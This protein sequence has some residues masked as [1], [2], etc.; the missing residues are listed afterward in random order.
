MRA[1]ISPIFVIIVG[2]QRANYLSRI[3]EYAI[4][5][6]HWDNRD[7]VGELRDDIE[8]E[9]NSTEDLSYQ[10]FSRKIAQEELNAADDE[11]IAGIVIIS[12][13]RE[14]LRLSLVLEFDTCDKIHLL[15][16]FHIEYE[17]F[18]KSSSQ[19]LLIVS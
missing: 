8:Y 9:K 1:C 6:I 16:Q 17:D 12:F 13:I 11:K 15:D 19:F 14:G 2:R 3:L 18:T 4:G 5:V 7:C 10:S